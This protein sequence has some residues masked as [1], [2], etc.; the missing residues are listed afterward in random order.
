M[1]CLLTWFLVPNLCYTLITAFN[2]PRSTIVKI[3]K[4]K[5]SYPWQQSFPVALSCKLIAEGKDQS[6]PQS[7]GANTEDSET[8]PTWKKAAIAGAV[9]L[10]KMLEVHLLPIYE[11]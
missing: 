7:G 10:E 1:V 6:D 8:F 2:I 5:V 11:L 3:K 4:S 9:S